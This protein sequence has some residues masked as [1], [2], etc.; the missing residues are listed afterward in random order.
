MAMSAL[1][2]RNLDDRV[3]ER[4]RIRAARQR[5]SM[6]AEIRVILTDAVAEPGEVPGL[7]QALTDRFAEL[8]GV[9][10]DLP[11]RSTPARAAGFGS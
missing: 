3:K 8:G 7:L 10:L 4:I 11:P 9:E 5:R 1:S 6:E 2:I